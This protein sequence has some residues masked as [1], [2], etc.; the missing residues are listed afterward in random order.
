MPT[1]KNVGCVVEIR[2]GKKS[3]AIA[4]HCLHSEGTRTGCAEVKALIAESEV[5]TESPVWVGVADFVTV[6]V[7]RDHSVVVIVIP[8]EVARLSRRKHRTACGT[9]VINLL[10]CLPYAAV[11]HAAEV[12]DGMSYLNKRY[13]RG[14]LEKSAACIIADFSG[15]SGKTG[16]TV[17]IVGC[18]HVHMI[19]EITAD[20]VVPRECELYTPC[21]PRRH[22]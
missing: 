12:A 21:S 9:R 17:S 13:I 4:L 7:E 5:D 15:S 2:V 18:V 11:A 16:H 8:D 22:H 19:K 14:V 6:A 3:R 10:L 20:I 1:I